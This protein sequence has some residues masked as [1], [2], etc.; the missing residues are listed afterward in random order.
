MRLSIP[1]SKTVNITYYYYKHVDHL[2]VSLC[3]DPYDCYT[4][5]LSMLYICEVLLG[6]INSSDTCNLY[7]PL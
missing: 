6:L 3:P 5:N 1:I 4:A 7:M 2:T